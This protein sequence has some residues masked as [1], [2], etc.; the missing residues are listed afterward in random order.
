MRQFVQDRR[1]EDAVLGNNGAAEGDG[2]RLIRAQADIAGTRADVIGDPFG[3]LV[4]DRDCDLVTAL[5]FKQDGA[6]RGGSAEV[7][8]ILP[9]REAVQQVL[10]RAFLVELRQRGR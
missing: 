8:A 9:A 4:H 1:A 10:D 5:R 6:R 2:E 3:V 7:R